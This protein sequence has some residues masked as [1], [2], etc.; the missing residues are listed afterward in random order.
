MNG[1]SSCINGCNS[2]GSNYSHLLECIL[3]DMTKQSG[4]AGTRLAGQK[5]EPSCPV[6]EIKHLLKLPVYLYLSHSTKVP[7]K[8]KSLL[9]FY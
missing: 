6:H 7:I 2:R 4:L 8:E 1:C 9:P 5:N 3:A